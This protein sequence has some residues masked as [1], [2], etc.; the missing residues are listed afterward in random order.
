MSL[1]IRQLRK[2]LE[3]HKI[4]I[5]LKIQESSRSENLTEFYGKEYFY[6]LSTMKDIMRI[7]NKKIIAL[8]KPL[9]LFAEKVFRGIIFV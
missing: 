9:R 8:A 2:T 4:Q 3:Y 6:V 7:Q 5:S 1:D